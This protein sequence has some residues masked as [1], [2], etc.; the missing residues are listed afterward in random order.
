MA[1]ESRTKAMASVVAKFG[2]W[3]PVWDFLGGVVAGDRDRIDDAVERL[4]ERRAEFADADDDSRSNA[5]TTQHGR[6]IGPLLKGNTVS[7]RDYR[8]TG[9]VVLPDD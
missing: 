7:G 9:P 3:T 4:L 8:P 1:T 5:E 6:H 2:G